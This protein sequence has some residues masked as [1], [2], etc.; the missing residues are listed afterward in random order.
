[1]AI[2]IDRVDNYQTGHPFLAYDF[3]A[4]YRMQLVGLPGLLLRH[5]GS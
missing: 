2:L 5:P 4:W 3:S 1:M